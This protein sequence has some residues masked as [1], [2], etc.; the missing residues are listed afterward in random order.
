MQHLQD[1]SAAC[2]FIPMCDISLHICLQVDFWLDP[3]STELPVDIRVPRFSLI[4]VKEYLTFHNIPFT[5]MIENVQ[6]CHPQN[7]VVY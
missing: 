1:F 2:F 7:T 6:V 5:V 4:P 3:V